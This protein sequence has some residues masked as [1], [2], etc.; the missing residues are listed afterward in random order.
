VSESPTV[1]KGKGGGPFPTS[2]MQ[3]TSN[4]KGKGKKVMRSLGFD[5]HAFT[6]K[7][8]GRIHLTTKR[9][10]KDHVPSLFTRGGK[11]LGATQTK[12]GVCAIPWKEE[13]EFYTSLRF[14]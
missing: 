1:N 13:E 12:E 7:V 4:R 3:F 2:P 6:G 10:G 8:E 11:G 5:K 14:F 9:R